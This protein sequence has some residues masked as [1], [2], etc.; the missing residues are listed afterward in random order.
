MNRNIK[1][2]LVFLLTIYA[3]VLSQ[4]PEDWPA[5]TSVTKPGSRWWWMGS[6]VDEANLTKNLESYASAGMGSMEITPIYGVQGNDSAEVDFLSQKWMKL[7]NHTQK[8]AARLNLN[9][10]MSTGTGWPFG[11][12]SV[13]LQDAACKLI[14]LEFQLKKAKPLT[15]QLK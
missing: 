10:D 5:E 14:T 13:S 12:P 9:I 2:S 7:Y 3:N 1:L 4:Q 11:G 6:A 8:E 15:N